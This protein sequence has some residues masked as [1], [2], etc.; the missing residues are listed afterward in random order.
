MMKHY[1]TEHPELAREEVEF[2][3][4][5]VK[6]SRS[7][8]DR[9]IGESIVIKETIREGKEEVLN[10]KLKYNHCILLDIRDDMDE[11][12][13]FAVEE[14]TKEKIRNWQKRIK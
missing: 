13:E 9:K 3:F 5:I 4:K 11:E 6:Q 7:A 2:S 12:K 10:S 14:E 8:F 1:I